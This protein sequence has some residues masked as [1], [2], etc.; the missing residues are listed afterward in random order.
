MNNR[1]TPPTRLQAPP[2]N[3]GIPLPPKHTT[4]GTACRTPG[5]TGHLRKKQRK[6]QEFR[7]KKQ[8]LDGKPVKWFNDAM[9]KWW[10]VQWCY[11][12]IK[13]GVTLYISCHMGHIF[14]IKIVSQYI[15]FSFWQVIP[16]IK[17]IEKHKVPS[18]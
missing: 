9:V 4:H 11:D 15:F 6:K 2:R 17:Y 18:T 10:M 14:D 1:V 8:G 3:T 5:R 16:K 12:E 7:R 13:I